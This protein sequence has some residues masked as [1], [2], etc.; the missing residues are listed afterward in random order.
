MV[1]NY[2]SFVSDVIVYFVI[3]KLDI[4]NIQLEFILLFIN[5]IIFVPI[6]TSSYPRIFTD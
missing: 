2:C 3:F 5:N 4:L 6:S 1:C